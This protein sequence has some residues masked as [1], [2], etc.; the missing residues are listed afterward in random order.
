MIKRLLVLLLGIIFCGQVGAQ[1][2]EFTPEWNI[3]V[4]FG[5]TFSS[6]SIIPTYP[7]LSVK[8]KSIFQFHGGVAVRY[9][10]ERN[11]GF[12]AE[13]NYSQM[14]WEENFEGR[15][16]ELPDG[17]LYAG[18]DTLF[19]HTH[20]LNY[21]EIPFLT[22]IYFGHNKVRGF[23]NIGPKVGF[24]ISESE[25]INDKLRDYLNQEPDPNKAAVGQYGKKAEKKIDYGLTAGAGVELRTGIGNFALEGRYYMGFGDIYNNRKSDYFSRSAN[26]VISAK[27]TYYIKAF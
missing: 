17:T 10:T 5:P 1:K 22:H 25:V 20:K 18:A 3:G 16:Y 24:L 15:K 8:T 6:L 21:L 26:R 19:Q 23:F 9:I 12:I 13:L 11:L 2:K 27:L 14:G 7:V 4:G